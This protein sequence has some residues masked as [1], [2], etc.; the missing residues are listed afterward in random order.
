MGQIIGSGHIDWCQHTE[1][2]NVPTRGRSTLTSMAR[3]HWL[4]WASAHSSSQIPQGK[5]IRPEG[6]VPE[7]SG[8]LTCWKAVGRVVV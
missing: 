4:W 7:R 8:L 3:E 5:G 1:I 2:I 6:A